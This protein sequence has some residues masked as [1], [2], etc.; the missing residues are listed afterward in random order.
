[1]ASQTNSTGYSMADWGWAGA[2]GGVGIGHF[3]ARMASMTLL[4]ASFEDPEHARLIYLAAG[5]LVLVAVLVIVG[6]VWWWRSAAVEHPSLAPLE[7]MSSKSFWKGDHDDRRNRLDSV[8]P[9][10]A[11]PGDTSLIVPDPVDFLDADRTRPI[12]FDDLRDVPEPDNEA[13]AEAEGDDDWRT[14]PLRRA[15]RRKVVREV[16]RAAPVPDRSR[17][18]M[19]PLLRNPDDYE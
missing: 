17:V 5:G 11:E 18:P 14:T 1:M 9:D 6:T 4:A 3:R 16:R 2:A 19:D 15:P 8:R 10:G 13:E 7:V 12:D